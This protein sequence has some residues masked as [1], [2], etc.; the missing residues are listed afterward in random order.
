MDQ[1]EFEKKIEQIKT[2]AK[3]Q[4][5]VVSIKQ[6]EDIFSSMQLDS[7]KM[8][9]V[10]A[11]IKESKIGI[12][13]PVDPDSFLTKE[14]I[15]YLD[16]YLDEL[17]NIRQYTVGEKETIFLSAMANEVEA[18]NRLIESFLLQVVEIAKLYAGQGVLLEDL[19]GE[20]NVALTIG[21][22][23]LGCLEMPSEIEGMIAKM[24]MD[25]M[26]TYITENT[27]V[28]KAYTTIVKKV[29]EVADKAKEM[30]EELGRK[31]TM[32]ELVQKTG[33]KEDTIRQ[34]VQF[35]AGLIEDIAYEKAE[36]N[37]V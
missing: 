34:I 16:I 20:G 22:E 12:G 28:T 19:I 27:D 21:S 29:N 35:S 1:K 36:S 6:T 13:E 14:D 31:V 4:D 3:V 2:L 37:L 33:M 17:G 32:K 15:S 25:A 24:I 9:L 8:Q 10:Y 5:N 7:E 18:K 30:A 23:M 11:F 26:E